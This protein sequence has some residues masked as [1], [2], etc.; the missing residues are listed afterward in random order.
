[1]VNALH[2]GLA[3]AAALL[4]IACSS[5][6]PPELVA[7]VDAGPLSLASGSPAVATAAATGAAAASDASTPAPLPTGSLDPKRVDL[8]H[9]LVSAPNA[10]G[11]IRTAGT[12]GAIIGVSDVRLIAQH[13]L[14]KA[15]YHELH[16]GYVGPHQDTVVEIVRADV[17]VAADGSFPVTSLGTHSNFVQDTDE[18]DLIPLEDGNE[19]GTKS[20]AVVP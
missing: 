16:F 10:D 8:T 7:A 19:V 5:A 3:V 13:V 17:A 15:L 9:V 4:A 18:L 1:M 12:A 6:P 20:T 14:S 11:V 2:R